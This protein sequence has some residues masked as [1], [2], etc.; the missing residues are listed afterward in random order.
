VLPRRIGKSY[1][2]VRAAVD[3]ATRAHGQKHDVALHTVRKRVKRLRHA[4]EA[5]EV[6][7]G[8]P[9]KRMRRRGQQIQRT[10]GDHHDTVEIRRTLRELGGRA[11]LDGSNGFTFGLLH[12]QAGERA[13]Q[14]EREFAERWRSLEKTTAGRWM[15]V[16]RSG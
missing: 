12:G 7:I 13:A 6:V 16:K 11:H 2:A 14:R 1:R 3:A 4:C 10:L 5:V 9:A 15:R 8:K